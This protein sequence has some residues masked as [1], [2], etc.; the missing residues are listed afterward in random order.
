[1]KLNKIVFT[2][3]GALLGLGLFGQDSLPVKVK[4]ESIVITTKGDKKEKMTIVVDGDNITVNGKPVAEFGG[5]NITVRKTN[6]DARVMTFERNKFLNSIDPKDIERIEVIASP[7]AKPNK[8]VLGVFTDNNEKGAKIEEIS[9]NGA[10]AKAGLKVDDIIM[11]IDKKEITKENSILKILSDYK[12]NDKVKVKYERDGKTSTVNVILD[13]NK[14]KKSVRTGFR[15]FGFNDAPPPPAAL[16]ELRESL[17][18]MGNMNI[19]GDFNFEDAQGN[20]FMG[21][22]KPRFGL[23]IEDTEAANGVKILEVDSDTPAATA[24]LEKNDIITSINGV[25]VSNVDELKAQLK[26]VKEG[27]LYKLELLRNGAKKDVEV[28]IPKRLKRSGI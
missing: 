10:A 12:P 25:K 19:K 3:T 1:M 15:T 7:E 28:K 5:E 8:A 9:A 20:F 27:S 17:K 22:R 26:D 6:G 11:A 14:L 4:S 2:L 21:N 18:G 24:G 23:D 13:S 16:H